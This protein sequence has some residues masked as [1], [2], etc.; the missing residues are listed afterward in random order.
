MQRWYTLMTKPRCEFK[1]AVAL[2]AQG[3]GVY[4]PV[5]EYHGK[6]GDLLEKPFHATSSRTS[7][8]TASVGPACSGRRAC[9][10]S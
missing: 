5:I 7:T 2:E 9:P 8:G 10:E 3:V 6:R 4:V 1:V